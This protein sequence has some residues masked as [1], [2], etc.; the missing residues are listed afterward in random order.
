MHERH[1]PPTH[2]PLHCRYTEQFINTPS[3][4]NIWMHKNLDIIIKISLKKSPKMVNTFRFHTCTLS[5]LMAEY[6][7]PSL[8]WIKPVSLRKVKATIG[9]RARRLVWRH[10]NVGLIVEWESSMNTTF[11]S[12]LWISH[13]AGHMTQSSDRGEEGLNAEKVFIHFYMLFFRF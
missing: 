13:I 5:I 2:R 7:S 3:S 12:H 9:R 1:T 11:V 8:G 6:F 4:L 10:Q